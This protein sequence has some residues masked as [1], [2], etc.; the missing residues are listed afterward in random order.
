MTPRAGTTKVKSGCRTCKTRRVK[1]DEGWPVCCR[2]LSTGRVCEGYG[3]WGGGGNRYGRRSTGPDT[4]RSLKL[5]YAPQLVNGISKDES[6]YLEWFTYRTAMKLPGA[7]RFAFWDT[8]LFQAISSEPAILHAVL[9]LSSAHRRDKIGVDSSATGR[10]PDEQE[11]FTLKH[12]S[13]AI[14]HL[15][16]HFSTKEPSSIRV[17]LIACLMFVMMEFLRG[18]YKAGNAHLQN[19]LKLLDEFHAQSSS[20]DCYSLFLEPCC[21]SVDAWIIQAFI[22]LDVQA[23]FLGYGSRYLSMVLEDYTSEV[24]RPKF[25]FQSANQARQHLDRIF[26]QIFHLSHECQ[27]QVRPPDQSCPGADLLVRQR[28]IKAKLSSWYQA[29]KASR[30]GLKTKQTTPNTLAYYILRI[31][32]SMAEIM[33]D[34][35][36]WPTD[37]SRYDARTQEF[38]SIMCQMKYIRS[39]TQSPTLIGII[40]FSDMSSSVADLG[41]LPILFYVATKCRVR[42]IRHDAVENL[43]TLGHKEGIWNAPLAECVAREVVEIEE[44]DFYGDSGIADEAASS[45]DSEKKSTQQRMLP[46]SY[47]LHD[48]EVELPEDYGGTVALKSKRTSD[49]CSWEC[50]HREY[51]YDIQTQSW[52]DKEER[53]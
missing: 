20:V 53:A 6:R 38:D 52:R 5:F 48:V 37:Q 11:Q 51:V 33:I 25:T 45:S 8:L 16:P 31:Y 35:C 1:C 26:N 24:T 46:E 43:S 42:R 14:R 39:L 29:F 44:G 34:T 40:H 22:R 18:H 21:D 49:G 27:R 15:Q 2:C 3:I 30:T 32:Y 7:F 41:A 12:Y 50:I 10:A 28:R 13:R 23:K 19:G 4:S 17:T 36:L 9:A 47:R